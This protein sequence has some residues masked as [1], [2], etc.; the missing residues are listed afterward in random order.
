MRLTTIIEFFGLV[1]ATMAVILCLIGAVA[2]CYYWIKAGVGH[3]KTPAKDALG[4]VIE[5]EAKHI[6]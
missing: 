2:F 1:F 5:L 4:K 6:G 3:S